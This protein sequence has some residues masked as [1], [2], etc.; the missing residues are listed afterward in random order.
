MKVWKWKPLWKFW[1]L[2]FSGNKRFRKS[3]GLEVRVSGRSRTSPKAHS[4]TFWNSSS[5]H[6][7]PFNWVWTTFVQHFIEFLGQ[8]MNL[9]P[10]NLKNKTCAWMNS[11]TLTLYRPPKPFKAT[12]PIPRILMPY[13]QQ[14]P[15]WSPKCIKFDQ[16]VFSMATAWLVQMHIKLHEN[17]V[18]A[19]RIR[20]SSDQPLNTKNQWNPTFPSYLGANEVSPDQIL[21]STD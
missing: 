9:A 2:I 11:T 16:N 13:V 17:S 8:K 19:S 18:Q 3:C 5:K 4:A 14:F 7:T 6:H 10:R 1:P 20:F 12:T 15:L 21:G